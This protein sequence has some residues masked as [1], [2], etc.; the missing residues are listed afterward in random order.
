MSIIRYA[1]AGI[2][3]L[4]AGLAGTTRPQND[5]P[6]HA[7][8]EGSWEGDGFGG[9]SEEIWSAPSPEGKMMGVYR[10]HKGDG[11]LNFY[12]FL[13]LDERGMH[14]KHFT[15]E[16]HAWEEKEEYL[17]FEKI[18]YVRDSLIF[19]GLEFHY[20]PPDSM[21]I[22]LKMR[23]AEGQVRTEVFNMKRKQG[24]ISR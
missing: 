18:R 14:L 17:T 13:V 19:K 9:R 4:A 10:H 6:I 15:P 7:W 11:S 3:L 21:R 12:E 8:L 16:L 1:V 2:L 22:Y 23:N 24:G 20:L 5:V